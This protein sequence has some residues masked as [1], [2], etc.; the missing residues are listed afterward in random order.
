MTSPEHGFWDC[1]DA[2]LVI[3]LDHRTDRWEEIRS[4]L[5]PLVPTG[6]LH[7]LPAVLGRTLPGYGNGPWFRRTK[8]AGTWGGRA[9]CMLSHRNALRL[10]REY[11]WRRVLILEDDARVALPLQGEAGHE[12]A[13]FLERNGHDYGV[14]FL[15]FTSPQKPVRRLLGL[16]NG[17]A[18]F[19]IGG[20]STTHA[21]VVD[22]C[23]YDK[24]LAQLPADD[25]AAWAWVARHV[26]I[27]RWYS[28]H[29]DRLARVAALSPQ[30]VIQGASFSDIT[31]RQADYHAEPTADLLSPLQ[32]SPA[33]WPVMNALARLGRAVGDIRRILKGWLRR[34]RGL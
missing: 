20:C 14:L 24:L 15:G 16:K 25:L 32:S 28:L 10:A 7:R 23:L 21:Y 5:A 8:R 4:H 1:L 9:G 31:E 34:I 29:L 22:A 12:L 6:K 18:V 26:A 17:P 33:A 13:T 19:Q 11:G 27:D 30:A 2:V 3:N